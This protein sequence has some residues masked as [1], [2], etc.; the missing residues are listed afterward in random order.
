MKKNIDHKISNAS[1][2]ICMK[3]GDYEQIKKVIDADLQYQKLVSIR[4]NKPKHGSTVKAE[5]GKVR[6]AKAIYAEVNKRMISA[7]FTRLAIESDSSTAY[8][9][10]REFQAG[11]SVK[12]IRERWIS[13]QVARLDNYLRTI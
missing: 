13:D 11:A 1:L 7:G 4:D 5:V 9:I 12:E 6:K 3:L 10:R 8:F 2:E